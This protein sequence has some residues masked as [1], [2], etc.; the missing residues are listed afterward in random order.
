LAGS[1]VD[2]AVEGVIT[3]DL[4]NAIQKSVVGGATGLGDIKKK[5]GLSPAKPSS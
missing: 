3:L 1:K 5:L 4:L 2:T